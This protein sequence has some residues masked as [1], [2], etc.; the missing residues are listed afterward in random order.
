M[1][2]DTAIQNV[3]NVTLML[4]IM[5]KDP[6]CTV[7]SKST[8]TQTPGAVPVPVRCMYQFQFQSAVR[9]KLRTGTT[10]NAILFDSFPYFHCFRILTN[11]AK[12]WVWYDP[13]SP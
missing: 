2:H 4:S 8:K 13:F 11:A 10:P 6:H 3:Q 9:T 7:S 1:V 12:K 5:D